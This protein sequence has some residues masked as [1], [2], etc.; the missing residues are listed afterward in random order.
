MS[1][2][3][4]EVSPKWIHV[5]PR[6][7]SRPARRRTRPRRGRSLRSRSFTASTVN[8]AAR[9]ACSS[10]SL[11]PCSPSSARQ[12]LARRQLDLAPRF[13]ASLVGP[14]TTEL[15]AGVAGDH[16]FRL[17]PPAGGGGGKA[18]C[19]RAADVL[20]CEGS[21]APGAR[22]RGSGPRGSPRCAR[23]PGRRTRRARP[24]ASARSRGSRPGRRPRSGDRTAARR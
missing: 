13:H 7:P 6:R 5:R 11:G 17:W 10:A 4:E 16:F 8:V 1:S 20:A 19:G 9:I 2:T 18:R 21:A 14:Q 23:C 22:T 24:G 3:S 15:G 12:L